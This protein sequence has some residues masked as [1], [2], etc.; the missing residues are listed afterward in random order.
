MAPADAIVI[1]YKTR[2]KPWPIGAGQPGLNN[3]VVVHPGTAEERHVGQSRTS[4][5]AGGR[6][7]NLT[8]GGGGWGEPFDRDPALVAHDVEMGLV[9]LEQAAAS[10]GVVVD[11]ATFHVDEDGTERLR[12]K[13][14]E[15]EGA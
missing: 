2:T 10:Y 3:T 15:K 1:N 11:P 9:S 5:E 13:R 14:P 7:V 12:S 6:M 8:G 4:F